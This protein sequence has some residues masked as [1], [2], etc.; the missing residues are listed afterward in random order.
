MPNIGPG[1]AFVRSKLNLSGYRL[2][3]VRLLLPM[4]PKAVNIAMVRPKH[5]VSCSFF[6]NSH[7]SPTTIRFLC[8]NKHMDEAMRTIFHDAIEAL[9][10][11]RLQVC[12]E[13]WLIE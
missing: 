3:V 12:V 11:C 10:C 8:S 1:Y 2:L 6:E 9:H 4:T 5:G 13:T 7:P